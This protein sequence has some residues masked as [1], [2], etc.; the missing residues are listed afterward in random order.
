MLVLAW[1]LERRPSQEQELTVRARSQLPSLPSP[2][3][4]GQIVRGLELAQLVVAA[5]KCSRSH[6]HSHSRS[7]SNRSSNWP[8]HWSSSYPYQFYA[9]PVAAV[10]YPAY[11]ASQHVQRPASPPRTIVIPPPESSKLPPSSSHSST[12]VPA[13]DRRCFLLRLFG[14]KKS[15]VAQLPE[16]RDRGLFADSSPSSS[17]SSA[18]ATYG[19]QGGFGDSGAKTVRWIE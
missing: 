18:M 7:H 16:P 14:G 13:R 19:S 4:P 6:S 8:S 1:I 12:P 2:S 17:T 11:H 5:T 10:P 3:Q 9:Y 15:G